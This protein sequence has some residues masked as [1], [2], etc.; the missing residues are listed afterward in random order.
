MIAHR[1]A[2][3]YAPENTL[4]AF[5]LGI[6]MGADCLEL[7]VVATRDGALIVRHENELS[8][9]TDVA[10]RARFADRRTTKRVDNQTRSGW[11][12]ED[13]TVAEIKQLRTKERMRATRPHNRNLDGLHPVPTLDEVLNLAARSRTPSGGRVGLCI[14]I[15]NSTYFSSVGLPVEDRLVDMLSDHGY[16]DDSRGAVFIESL[17]TTNLK[18]LAHLTN[19]TLVQLIGCSGR[20]HDLRA[21]GDHRTFADLVTGSGLRDIRGYAGVLG[22]CKTIAIPRTPNDRLGQPAAVIDH[23]HQLGLAVHAWTFR[24]EN[25]FLPTEFQRQTDRSA[26]GDLAGEI[27]V[28]LSAGLDGIVTDNPDV[29]QTRTAPPAPLRRRVRAAA[30]SWKQT[31]QQDK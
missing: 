16:H 27:G 21:Q 10:S 8:I 30:E 25:R 1:G 19:L 22:L 2:S 4:A 13:F 9:T 6:S 12:S 28:F 26:P 20:P 31:Q 18:Y 7:D 23:A 14:E 5:A 15:K 29:K 24:R 11:F 17:E 3:G